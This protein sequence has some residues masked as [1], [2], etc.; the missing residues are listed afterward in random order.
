MEYIK[1]HKSHDLVPRIF[2]SS[3]LEVFKKILVLNIFSNS[4]E[5][6]LVKFATI[7]KVLEHLQMATSGG[8]DDKICFSI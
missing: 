2:R 5:T 6:Y 7:E 4:K 1:L 8:S 3:P